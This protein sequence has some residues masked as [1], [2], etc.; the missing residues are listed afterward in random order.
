MPKIPKI[1]YKANSKTYTDTIHEVPKGGGKAILLT[2]THTYT[3]SL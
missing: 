1:E 3:V 2:D